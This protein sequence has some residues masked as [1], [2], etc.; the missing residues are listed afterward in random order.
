MSRIAQWIDQLLRRGV[1]VAARLGLWLQLLL[2]RVLAASYRNF[3]V[4][5]RFVKHFSR[6]YRLRGWIILLVSLSLF[7]V[8]FLWAKSVSRVSEPPKGVPTIDIVVPVASR[9]YVGEEARLG[10]IVAINGCRNPVSV[11]VSL[12]APEAG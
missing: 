6:I 12:G 9:S 4:A 1:E 11:I 5:W 2:P 3:G 8:V 7:I 10:V